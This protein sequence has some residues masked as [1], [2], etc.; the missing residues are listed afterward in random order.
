MAK[1]ILIMP[2]LPQRMG[3]PY[4]GQQY[5]A[6]S[7]LAAGHEVR[8]VD[9][10][11]ARRA[12]DEDEVEALVARE[13]PDWIGMTLFTYNAL[14]GYRLAARL[15][16]QG[17]LLVAGGPHVTVCPEEALAHGFDLSV[18]GEGERCVVEL[19]EALAQ[20]RSWRGLAGTVWREGEQVRRG[21]PRAALEALDGL[22]LPMESYGCYDVEAYAEGGVVVPGGLMTS[23]GCPARC[24]FCANY[25]TGRAYRWRSAQDV[26]AELVA[27]RARHGVAHFP[28]WDDAFTARRPRLLELCDAME[29]EP[30]LRGA[31][32]TCITPG[33]M[34]RP[35]DLQRMRR[36]GCVVINFGLESGDAQILKEIGK[37]VSPERVLAS[38]RAARDAGMM[39][40][41]NFMFGFPQEDEAALERTLALMEALAPDVDFFNNRGVLVPFPGTAVYDQWAAQF[42]LEGWWLRPEMIVDEPNPHVLDPTRA[43]EY[44]ERDPTLALDF[45]RYRAPVRALIEAGVRW[46]AQHNARTIARLSQQASLG[47]LGRGGSATLQQRAAASVG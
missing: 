46:K 39:T 1:V 10:A 12:P 19:T 28:F 25:V 43:Q 22:P 40:I 31:T 20:G 26:V 41:V 21:P 24:T 29:G 42:G 15:R 9:M 4:L 30:A 36:A 44:L 38:V 35:E 45:F 6:A 13:A 33:N 8:C 2:R 17:A 14:A 37:G 16:G 47:P 5:I 34:V 7:L 18:V 32:W 23:R 3:A 11:A 27:L